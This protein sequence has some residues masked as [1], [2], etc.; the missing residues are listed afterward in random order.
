MV[1]GA[2]GK[3]LDTLVGNRLHFGDIYADRSYEI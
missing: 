1:K 3:I 2:R